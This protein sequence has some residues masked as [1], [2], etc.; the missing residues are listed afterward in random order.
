MPVKAHSQGLSSALPGSR[1]RER[2]G[3]G[4]RETLVT[5]LM[6]YLGNS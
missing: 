2:A 5:R 1:L 4:G 6:V 3:A